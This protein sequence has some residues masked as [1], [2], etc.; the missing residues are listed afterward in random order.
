M[1]FYNKNP[2]PPP[3]SHIT[4]SVRDTAQWGTSA[5][6]HQR[7][8]PARATGPGDLCAAAAHGRSAVHRQPALRL[9]PAA[10]R[11][12]GAT[13]RQPGALLPG[14]QRLHGAFQGL[15]LCGIH[16]EGLRRQG[17]VGTTGEAAG[18]PHAV[19][20]LDGGGLPHVPSAALQMPVRG[21]FALESADGSRPPQRPR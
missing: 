15:W 4:F 9:H 13:L 16:E 21:P 18:L 2:R 8:A 14:V 1:C 10:V 17:Q 20:A 3:V 11:G 19:C 5:V 6:R 12:A 7:I